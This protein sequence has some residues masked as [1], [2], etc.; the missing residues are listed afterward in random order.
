MY[1]AC[2]TT[3]YVLYRRRLNRDP[4]ETPFDVEKT[5]SSRG[6]RGSV[7]PFMNPPPSSA[8]STTT[9][10]LGPIHASLPPPPGPIYPSGPPSVG[11]V[12]PSGP[13][14]GGPIFRP[15]PSAGPFTPSIGP[16]P[17]PADRRRSM[18]ANRRMSTNP[19]VPPPP[20]STSDTT[21]KR[22]SRPSGHTSMAPSVSAHSLDVSAVIN[23]RRR[24]DS[25]ASV[26]EY[27]QNSRSSGRVTLTK[28][29]PL[30]KFE[31]AF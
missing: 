30:S 12:Y 25:M 7:L 20:V 23:E 3:A 17:T 15:G 5:Q 6:S 24:K 19:P 13:S 1:A 28:P 14:L 27:S 11:Y 21:A 18:S 26:S 8:P 2:L 4:M 31:H 22:A 29:M 16:P 10:F 9:Q